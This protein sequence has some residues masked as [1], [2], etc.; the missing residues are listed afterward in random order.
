MSE[1]DDLE[2]LSVLVTGATSGIGRAAAMRLAGGGAE[3]IVHGRDASRG[4]AVVDAIGAAG[5]KGHFAAA[6]L[7][8]PAELLDFANQV[9][10]EVGSLSP[11]DDLTL[12]V[13][14]VK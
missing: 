14:D 9:D 4:H 1:R 2:G 5:G 10:R 13:V 6:D 12:I 8:D 11:K 3:V 7:S